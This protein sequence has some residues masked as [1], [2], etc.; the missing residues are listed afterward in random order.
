MSKIL[1]S[2]LVFLCLFGWATYANQDDDI[3]IISRE[4]WWANEEYRYLDSPEWR[5]ITKKRILSKKQREEELK[6]LTPQER[7]E[8]W[9]QQAIN[10]DLSELR[11]RYLI[12]NFGDDIALNKT[13]KENNDRVLA[14]PQKYTNYVNSIVIHHT[15]WKYEDS[16]DAIRKI[17]KF[18]TLSRQWWDI[19]Y[20]YLIGMDGEIFEWR[21]GGDY[22]VWAHNKWNNRST[23]WIALIWSYQSREPSDVQ[24]EALNK[25]VLHLSKKYGIDMS[26]DDIPIHNTCKSSDCGKTWSL[27]TNYF[28]PLTW[29]RDGW[30]TACP[31]EKLYERIDEIRQNVLEETKG[32][33]PVK[34]PSQQL[35]KIDIQAKIKQLNLATSIQQRIKR[36]NEYNAAR[37]KFNKLPWDRV[38]KAV[39]KI[40]Q[41]KLINLYIKVQ[42]LWSQ[43][44]EPYKDIVLTELESLIGNHLLELNQ[45]VEQDT[46]W[47]DEAVLAY[48]DLNTIKIKLSYPADTTDI[49]ISSLEGYRWELAVLWNDLEIPFIKNAQDSTSFEQ[50]NFVYD[51]KRMVVN[52]KANIS[53]RRWEKIRVSAPEQGYLTITSWDRKPTWDTTGTLNDN[54]F[55]WD[56]VLYIQDQKLIV[57][58]E[59]SFSDYL[60]W[61]GEISDSEQPEKI[62]TIITAARTYARWYTTHARKFENSWYDWSDDP[63]VFQKYLGYGLEQRSPNINKIV[64]ETKDVVITYKWDL[65]KPW[66]HSSSNGRTVSFKQFCPNCED[67]NN[68]PFLASVKDYSP[69]A[70]IRKWHWVWI[71]GTWV[72]DLVNRGW[73]YSMIIKYFLPWTD[74]EKISNPQLQ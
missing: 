48:D 19:G 73:N 37:K 23:V 58:N 57:V 56:I 5:N 68:Y 47:E 2:F 65:I 32:L 12:E 49:S 33:T 44:N 1:T 53:M 60:K 9:K 11:N 46:L 22:V 28:H 16:Y 4:Q 63:D 24:M 51:G 42:I 67:K 3:E 15:E 69:E 13:I 72:S 64:D 30:H 29:H 59:L 7:L 43:D 54:T 6:E 36:N 17:Y 39:K 26:Q 14:W 55:R 8:Y 25:L 34:N 18:H 50:L 74:V 31:G 10:Y 20:N 27:Y 70:I 35:A 52:D 62:R 61:L 21:S 71:P 41:P 66:Y 45:V 38:E 40:K